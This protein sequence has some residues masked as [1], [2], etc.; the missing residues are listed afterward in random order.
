MKNRLRSKAD[1]LSYLKE[2]IKKGYVEDIYVFTVKEWES[3]R[4]DVIKKIMGRFSP[5][6]VAVRSSSRNEDTERSSQAGYFHSEIGVDS[7][8]PAALISS[9]ERVIGSYAE[10]KAPL[11]DDQVIVQTQTRSVRISGV[12]FTR[13]LGT[14]APYY[15]INY[16][17]IT[18]KTDTVTGGI[19]GDLVCIFRGAK[20]REA[21]EWAA[22]LDSVREIE[23]HFPKRSLDIEFAI[24]SAGKV[25]I[26]QVR[27]LA[28]NRGLAFPDEGHIGELIGSMKAKYSR[29]SRPIPH[30]GGSRTIFGDMPDWNPAEM[31]GNR[32]NTLDYSLYSFLITDSVWH[33]ARSS[34][35]YRDVYPGDLMI[36]FGKRP[37][38]DTRLSFNSLLPV[39]VPDELA[40]KIVDH[41]LDK[42]ERY[43]ERQDKIEF[44]I[45]WS[46]YNFSLERQLLELKKS[47][48]K[49]GE[50]EIFTR[51]LRKLTNGILD[52][53]EYLFARDMELVRHLTQRKAR[54]LSFR[55]RDDDSP[56]TLFYIAY[57]LLQ[58][59][60]KFGILPFA[61]LA[62][63]AFIGKSILMSL[64]DEGVI[65]GDSYHGFLNS[66]QTVASDFSAD[67]ARMQSGKLS[68]CDFFSSYGH[69]RP[70]TYDIT[71]LR[72]RD[73][74]KGFFSKKGDARQEGVASR[75][76]FAFP[77]A[78][79]SAI[80]RVME[81]DKINGSAKTLL[82]FIEKAIKL[83]ED[84]KLEFTRT[85]SEAIEF[86][87]LAGGKL[88]FT[89]E[90]LSQVDLNTLLK[91]RNPEYSDSDHA[92]RVIRQSLERHKKEKVWS[93]HLILPP[94]IISEK[95]I[96]IVRFYKARPNFITEKI[97][98]GPVLVYDVA[99]FMKIEDMREYI[100]FLENADPGYD[101]IFSR[102]PM[103]IVTK[104]G[105]VASH[106]AIRCA[107][108][109]IPA[110]I[111]CGPTIFDRLVSSRFVVID[112]AKQVLEPLEG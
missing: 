69:L 101:W 79:I 63:L 5:K 97:A 71:A 109:G 73:M 98:K 9:I 106:M 66:I 33:E 108:F 6:P 78:E 112:G 91:F 64:R 49:R 60:K 48:F 12:V 54:L 99:G 84:A 25:V 42:L 26:F 27:P 80:N 53:A 22:L 96:D 70:G 45:V 11:F 107:E 92:G 61:R 87:A 32:P 93:D 31:I 20:S 59:C 94:V 1:V 104:Y 47:G 105:G 89:R 55:N 111:G 19:S 95:D 77:A 7:A 68:L 57:N 34:L 16:D 110:A 2:T 23:G 14:N 75:E 37:Y 40:G 10:K 88:G 83:R 103:G 81:R 76:K 52:D 41:Y 30:L 38:I 56:W 85:L 50:I 39:D 29:F 15:I 17:G 21:G 8:S 35:G 36:S 43:P 24:T 86:L 65:S 74:K 28:A 3:A 100:I 46:C 51:A 18:G 58:N 82:T 4:P 44:E 102:K 67:L 90:D 13:G 62:R 72:Y